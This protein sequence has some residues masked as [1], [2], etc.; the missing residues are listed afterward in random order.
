MA[1]SGMD[2]NMSLIKSESQAV[3]AAVH[4]SSSLDSMQ[5]PVCTLPGNNEMLP[6]TMSSSP[7]TNNSLSP[8][9]QP[10]QRSRSLPLLDS[11]QG[12]PPELLADLAASERSNFPGNNSVGIEDGLATSQANNQGAQFLQR[13][14]LGQQQMSGFS[15]QPL[16]LSQSSDVK[17][18]LSPFQQP[19]VPRINMTRQ[20]R[21]LLPHLGEWGG[22]QAG[23]RLQLRGSESA[24]AGLSTVAPYGM[25]QG[26]L[27]NPSVANIY[28]KV[29]DKALGFPISETFTYGRENLPFQSGQSSMNVNP[30]RHQGI[31]LFDGKPSKEAERQ[32]NK[33]GRGNMVQA[34]QHHHENNNDKTSPNMQALSDSVGGH[35]GDKSMMPLSVSVS[36]AFSEPSQDSPASLSRHSNS[37]AMPYRTSADQMLSMINYNDDQ[38]LQEHGLITDNSVTG[39]LDDNFL[40]GSMGIGPPGSNRLTDSSN[41][42]GMDSSP[43]SVNN[44]TF[45]LF[46]GGGDVDDANYMTDSLSPQP[47]TGSVDS[48]VH[49]TSSLASMGSSSGSDVMASIPRSMGRGGGLVVGG[50]NPPDGKSSTSVGMYSDKALNL[51]MGES[52]GPVTNVS[53]NLIN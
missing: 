40:S 48:D 21:N 11:S 12:I 28:S 39:T 1:L 7:N 16:N 51:D 35:L 33:D 2:G 8:P 36:V 42:T 29:M 22:Y 34:H 5:N 19:M 38:L 41:L 20:V 25:A 4:R 43:P 37:P 6:T 27:F 24:V 47:L 15:Q 50:K 45:D 46:D 32:L 18:F 9:C 10:V 30:L 3:P 17:Q 44:E 31:H 13:D 52:S 26:Q 14:F 49:V 53:K 23:G